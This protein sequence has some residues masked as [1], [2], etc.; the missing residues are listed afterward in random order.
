[1]VIRKL[2]ANEAEALCRH[3]CRLSPEDRSWRFLCGL[4]DAA[5]AQHCRRLDWLR[6]V[7]VGCF[8]DGTLRGAAELQLAAD[9][10]PI[11][12]EAALSVETGWQNRGIATEL[13]RRLLVIA[14]NRWARG[15]RVSCRGDNWRMR[16]VA[17]KFS[18]RFNFSDELAAAEIATPTPDYASFCAEAIDDGFGWIG[19]CL[20]PL[21]PAVPALRQ[22]AFGALAIAD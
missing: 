6:T 18:A 20:D 13:M 3:L 1:M 17:A 8:E 2:V 5:V 10:F 14:R 19:A 16:R 12:C 9:G 4:S 22:R 11:V 7:V 21:L 15:V